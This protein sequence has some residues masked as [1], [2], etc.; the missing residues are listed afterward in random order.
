MNQIYKDAYAT[1]IM[2]DTA[3]EAIEPYIR[4]LTSDKVKVTNRLAAS[5][6]SISGAL[7][8]GGSYGDQGIALR[9][10]LGF[11]YN[12]RCAFTITNTIRLVHKTTTRKSLFL[13]VIRMSNFLNLKTLITS[14]C[15]ENLLAFI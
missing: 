15:Y 3:S 12:V 10:N 7:N 4:D 6:I 9:R 1:A 8:E 14:P 11:K 13:G 2:N 5:K